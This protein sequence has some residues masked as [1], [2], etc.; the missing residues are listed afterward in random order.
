MFPFIIILFLILL[1]CS[2]IDIRIILFKDN[3]ND[4]IVIEFI[5]LYGLI[6]Y[7]REYPLLSLKLMK[8]DMPVELRQES[9]AN[10]TNK[11][12]NE[13]VNIFKLEDIIKKV[14][15]SNKLLKKYN[16][17]FKYIIRKV[18]WKILI[19]ETE[20]G[21]DDAAI[22]GFIVGIL[23]II[24]SNILAYLENKKYNFKRICLNAKPN[25]NSNVINMTL[26]CI[27]SLRIGYIIIAGFKFLKIKI[28]DTQ[29]IKGGV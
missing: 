25:F 26:N 24:N 23:N 28:K 2:A 5:A 29:I 1:I 15:L 3:C 21:F 12:L 10:F 4:E 6:K 14:K 8:E 9:E 18:S 27:F 11:H 7:K 19:L 20:V 16:K 22:T 17:V 13:D